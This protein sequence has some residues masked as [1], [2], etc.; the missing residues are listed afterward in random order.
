MAFNDVSND[1]TKVWVKIDFNILERQ[2]QKAGS[3]GLVNVDAVLAILKKKA[4]SVIQPGNAQQQVQD[5]LCP[6]CGPDCKREHD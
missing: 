1:G 4:F 5:D 2:L 6:Y 3:F